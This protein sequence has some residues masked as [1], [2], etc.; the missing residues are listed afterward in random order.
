MA[1]LDNTSLIV[2]AVLTDKGREMLASNSFSIVKFA[3]G[4]D[5]IDYTMYDESN[6]NGPNFYGISIENMPILESSTYSDTA[7]KY[8]LTTLKPTTKQLPE[9]GASVPLTISLTGDGAV[10]ADYAMISPS[11][12][13]FDEDEEY[14]FELQ[15]D[16]FVDLILGDYA[17]QVKKVAHK[18]IFEQLTIDGDP[19]P[20]DAY[21]SILFGAK[22]TPLPLKRSEQD[23]FADLYKF[24]IPPNKFGDIT[25]SAVRA[26][27]ELYF[28]GVSGPTQLITSENLIYSEAGIV[29][30]VEGA[31]II[32]LG[33]T[34]S[35]GKG[36]TDEGDVPASEGEIVFATILKENRKILVEK[37]KG[38]F[39]ALGIAA[40]SKVIVTYTTKGKV[41]SITMYAQSINAQK[42]VITLKKALS[43]SIPASV[44]VSTS[45]P[46]DKEFQDD[47]PDKTG[48]DKS[49]FTPKDPDGKDTGEMKDTKDKSMDDE[50]K[51]EPETKKDFGGTKG[52]SGGSKSGGSKGGSKGGF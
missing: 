40:N 31:G 22:K 7:L 51:F 13:R 26:E 25:V 2:D 23:L 11:T 41:Q 47:I 52:S 17:D 20:K 27:G 46:A 39:K 44:T 3:L 34:D 48:E 6:S 18:V 38:G 4:D 43:A 35:S 50:K 10:S 33:L 21:Q 30:S 29:V 36:T 1:F 12:L 15:D 49:P 42:T 8:K 9:M 32:S 19:V 28:K 5:E 16:S 37:E 24:Y 45:A 14:M